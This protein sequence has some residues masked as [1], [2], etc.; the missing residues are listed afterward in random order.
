MPNPLKPD[1]LAM[2]KR[3]RH[4][5]VAWAVIAKTL[6]RSRIYVRRALDVEFRDH[7]NMLQANWVKKRQTQLGPPAPKPHRQNNP[8]ESQRLYVPADVL[9]DRDRRAEIAPSSV[10]AAL[11]GDPPIG[12]SALDQRKPRIVVRNE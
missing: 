1:E 4:K 8:L 6:G 9:A 11:M 3:L 7:R 5:G 10:T 2:A 12:R